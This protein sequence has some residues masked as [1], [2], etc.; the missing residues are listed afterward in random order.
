MESAVTVWGV[1][2]PLRDGICA[3]ADLHFP[4]DISPKVTYGERGNL[5]NVDTTKK[6]PAIVVR[7]PYGRSADATVELGRYF[8]AYGYVY[9]AVDVR[10]RG[11]SEGEFVPYRNE[12]R[13]GY[14][15]IEWVARQTWC[16]G[17]V[18]TLGGSYLGK[19]QWL[20]ALEKP[21]HLKAM[22]ALVSPSDPFVEWPT[23]TPDPMHVC[24]AFLT[25]DRAPQ[26]IHQVDWA[27]VYRHL[28][29]ISM[30]EAAGRYMPTWKEWF[31]H[32]SMDDWWREVC[33]QNRFSE[34]D[35]PVMHISGWYDDEQI[36]T[37]LNFEGMSRLAPSETT[38]RAQRLIMGP[39]PHQVNASTRIGDLDFGPSAVIDLRAEQLRFFDRWLKGMDNGVDEEAPVSLFV[40]GKNEW[41]K[42]RE[43]PLAR[44]RYVDWYCH[45]DGGANGSQGDGRLSTE[46]PGL[47]ESPDAFAYDPEEPVMFITEPTSSQIGGP[48]DYRDIHRRSDVLVYT[49]DAL[50]TPME[51]TGPVKVA[52]YASSSSPD[53]DFMAQLHDVWP[54][55]YA[56][57]LCD[58]MV[59]VRFRNGMDSP[60]FLE[61]GT[62]CSFTIDCWNT[63]HVFLSGHRIRI[64]ITSSAFPKYDRN[65]NTN[66]PLGQTAHSVVAHQVVFHD[67]DRPTRVILPV[68]QDL[69]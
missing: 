4:G 65:P 58:G 56:Q 8:A 14:D 27:R 25:S 44:T 16:T 32:C 23:G 41:R 24:W 20:T 69:R 39:W 3:A 34:I 42:E 31:D 13:D 26:N 43:W 55:G 17:E 57:R 66:E 52:L 18:G 6:V 49:S 45:S 54:N 35:L 64:H 40:M 67:R 2:I 38:R 5:L 50:A 1:R 19:V 62:V 47:S 9:V 11:D 33:Y 63:S 51:V 12:G 68:I 53:T 15:V 36:G 37:P 10:G 22:I 29:L 46:L 28:P 30:D 7:T 59:R 21:P 61:P 48:D 60:E